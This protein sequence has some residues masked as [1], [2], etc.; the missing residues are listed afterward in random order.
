MFRRLTS[1]RTA[2]TLVELLVVIAI[3]GVLVA[4]LL[5]AVQAARESARVTQCKNN[6]RQIAVATLRFSEEFGAFPPARLQPRPDDRDA[7]CGG[8]EP[9]WMVRLLPYLERQA[10]FADWRLYRPFADHAERL[11]M[12]TLSVYVCPSR[13]DVDSA[14]MSAT[15]RLDVFEDGAA[16]SKAISEQDQ[17]AP[18][19][20]C[21]PGMP[22][23]EPDPS[24][25]DPAAPI[26]KIRIRYLKGS[27]G[28][29]AGNHGDPSPGLG[30]LATDFYYGGNGTGIIISSR[31]ECAAGA[32]V[33]WID[34]ISPRNISDGLSNTFLVG[35]RHV[36]EEHFGIPPFDGA[37]FDGTH[38]ASIAAVAG[39]EF[40]ISPGPTF[41]AAQPCTFGSWHPE[42][43]QFAMADGSVRALDNNSDPVV[44]GRL[45]NRH[46]AD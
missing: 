10:S 43:C 21:P 41:A 7:P 30:G 23:P 11:R 40:P 15:F 8:A 33:D 35:E 25:E 28:D 39:P 5:P 13:R 1:R 18:R 29:Y 27:L 42:I 31:A 26:P 20:P 37:I 34:R 32:P 44:L 4:L 36:H 14:V 9:S 22:A 38:L 16:S 17:S 6:I 46:D 12:E 45:A 24:L 19:C 3:I 2:F